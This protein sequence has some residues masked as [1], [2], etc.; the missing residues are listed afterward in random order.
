LG[1]GLPK[2][3]AVSTLADGTTDVWEQNQRLFGL[4]LV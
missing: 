1:Q 3:R 2:R 4:R